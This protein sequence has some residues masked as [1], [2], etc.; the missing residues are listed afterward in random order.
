MVKTLAELRKKCPKCAKNSTILTRRSNDCA[1]VNTM[2]SNSSWDVGQIGNKLRAKHV[3]YE[4][5]ANNL[6]K[7]LC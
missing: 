1:K 7:N 6:Q 4:K 2:S 5:L 3:T